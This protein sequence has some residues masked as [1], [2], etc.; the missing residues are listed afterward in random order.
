[1]LEGGA[2]RIQSAELALPALRERYSD[3][4]GGSGSRDP[5]LGRAPEPRMHIDDV[6]FRRLLL[7]TLGRA[8]QASDR[9]SWPRSRG[10]M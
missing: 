2:V 8:P 5:I 7:L 10:A 3:E 4:D 1:M 6:G 9:V